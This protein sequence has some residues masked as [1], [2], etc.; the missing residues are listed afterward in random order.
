[1]MG[2][3]GGEGVW[4]SLG[5][6]HGGVRSHMDRFI[7]IAKEEEFNKAGGKVDAHLNDVAPRKIGCVKVGK[8]SSCRSLNLMFEAF[9]SKYS[10]ASCSQ[11]IAILA[12]ANRIIRLRVS[13]ANH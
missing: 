6:R 13:V 12:V 8:C 9:R 2:D 3:A 1:M 7:C 11:A 10:H 5:A 4:S